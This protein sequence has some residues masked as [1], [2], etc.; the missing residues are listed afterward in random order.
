MMEVV[1]DALLEELGGVRKYPVVVM[2]VI[3][4]RR[5]AKMRGGNN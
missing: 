4:R 5:R 3:M 1:E 2:M